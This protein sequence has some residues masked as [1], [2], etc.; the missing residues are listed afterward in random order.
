MP[1]L[2]SI[3][4]GLRWHDDPGAYAAGL[5]NELS[6][7]TATTVDCFSFS[8]YAGSM[9]LIMPL[10]VSRY[11]PQIVWGE[12]ERKHSMRYSIPLQR[13][14]SFSPPLL[15]L[16]SRD[17]DSFRVLSY[18]VMVNAAGQAVSGSSFPELMWIAWSSVTPAVAG[19]GLVVMVFVSARTGFSGCLSN[20]RAG[21]SARDISDGRTDF[22]PDVFQ[23]RGCFTRWRGDL[24]AGCGLVMVCQQKL[25]PR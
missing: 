22:W 7:Y 2:Q 3:W 5:L 21:G 19:L 11:S 23:P 16:D 17:Q 13:T 1:L 6:G 25:P 8:L 4:L 15:S 14:V 18:G 20:R 24:A 12:K 9:F 10:M